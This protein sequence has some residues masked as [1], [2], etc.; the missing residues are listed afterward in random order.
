MR[1]GGG[2]SEGNGL[3]WQVELDSHQGCVPGLMT[4]SAVIVFNPCR[5]ASGANHLKTRVNLAKL[6]KLR[7]DRYLV[8]GT[9]SADGGS[10]EL[11]SVL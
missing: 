6:T 1:T 10:R 5:V 4:L 8:T 2:G 3:S 7:S 11:H 9:I